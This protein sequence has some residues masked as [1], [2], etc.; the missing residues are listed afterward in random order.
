MKLS[1]LLDG[2]L[3]IKKD[4]KTSLEML[5]TLLKVVYREKDLSVPIE[6]VR[7]AILEQKRCSTVYKTG[8]MIPHARLEKLNDFVIAIAIPQKPVKENSGIEE[9]PAA[10][11][12]VKMMALILA[13]LKNPTL[14]LNTLSSFAKIS[15]DAAF[16]NKLIDSSPGSIINLIED[17]NIELTTNIT[18]GSIMNRNVISLGPE[19]TVKEAADVFFNHRFHYIPVMDGRQN[20][21]GEVT[22][23][24]LLGICI[25]DYVKTTGVKFL[26][27][28]EP[29]E[30]FLKKENTIKLKEIMK[31]PLFVLEEDAPVIQAILSFVQS[32]SVNLPVVK[33]GKLTGMVG[34]MDVLNKVLKV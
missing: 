19:N 5:D 18:I 27:H 32:K 15:E 12:P 26:K 29:L 7:A 1:S 11:T 31:K 23:I 20:F 9:P 2:E 25:P 22:L 28:F 10:E 3:I 13:S 4:F 6:E 8:I 24:D 21:I 33:N 17:R 16:F 34:Y 30:E 14:Y